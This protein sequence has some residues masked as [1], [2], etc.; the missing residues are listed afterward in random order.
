[1]NDW[2]VDDDCG[3]HLHLDARNESDDSLLAAAYA[4]RATQ[5]LWFSFVDGDRDDNQ[6]CHRTRWDLD[7]LHDHAGTFVRFILDNTNGRYEWLNLRAYTTH[8]TLEVRLHHASVDGEEICNWVKAH[9]RFMDW[10]TTV[11]YDGVRE[12]L[13]GMDYAEMFD[14]IADEVWKDGELRAY[15]ATRNAQAFRMAYAV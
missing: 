7:D 11:G 15:Y 3:F 4:Y 2:R 1:M 12:A 9:T 10:A 6:Y 13:D 5:E 14:F 8:T